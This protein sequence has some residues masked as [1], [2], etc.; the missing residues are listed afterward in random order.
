[1]DRG[2]AGGVL[3]DFW[4]CPSGRRL[5]EKPP[6]PDDNG[7]GDAIA[8]YRQKVIELYSG[9]AH[10]QG[11]AD[12]PRWFAEN[13][14][15]IEAGALTPLAQAASLT[16]LE[17]YQTAPNCIEAL[18]ALNRWPGRTSAPLDDYLRLW[19]AS[20]AELKAS[21]ALPVRL[22]ALLGRT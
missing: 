21:D 16:M 8:G 2:G 17:I 14:R 22:K 15:D 20:C 3:F 9:L 1:M 6:F 5:E 13:R 18:G 7:F 11:T 4:P 19:Q 12:F 10:D